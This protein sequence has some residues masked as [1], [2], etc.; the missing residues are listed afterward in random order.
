MC[1]TPREL[2]IGA[3]TRLLPLVICICEALWHSLLHPG[4]HGVGSFWA[5]HNSLGFLGMSS[6]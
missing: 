6:T 4:P 1:E 3:K 2:E 5:A